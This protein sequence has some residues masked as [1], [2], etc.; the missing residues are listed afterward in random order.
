VIYTAATRVWL[1][2]IA[3]SK[4][5]TRLWWVQS[6]AQLCMVVVVNPVLYGVNFPAMEPRK[7]HYRSCFI[8]K[9]FLILVTIEWVDCTYMQEW[10]GH[11][12]F[13]NAKV[14]KLSLYDTYHHLWVVS[15]PRR[16]LVAQRCIA[17]VTKWPKLSS[18]PGCL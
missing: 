10:C 17:K 1:I 11:A 12:I 15:W 14:S 13:D 18:D 3:A 7:Y 5:L 16:L 8:S 9:C 2:P 6:L 4:V